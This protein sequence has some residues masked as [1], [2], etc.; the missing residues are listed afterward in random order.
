MITME[1]L[2]EGKERLSTYYVVWRQEEVT[3][4]DY[5]QGTSAQE[6]VDNAR[7]QFVPKGARIIE[8]LKVV[9]NWK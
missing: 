6:A 5:V 1:R 4:S 7:V 3:D 8:V 2:S 9:N